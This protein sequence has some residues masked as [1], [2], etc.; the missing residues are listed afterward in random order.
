MNSMDGQKPLVVAQPADRWGGW[1]TDK[2]NSSTRGSGQ[3]LEGSALR[4]KFREFFRTFRLG[5]LYIYRE[6]LLRHYNR[7]EYYIEVDLKH[8][9][10]YDAD[11]LLVLQS[12]PTEVIPLFEAAVKDALKQILSTSGAA[13]VDMVSPP[14]FQIVFESAQSPHSLRNLTAEHVNTL[15]KVNK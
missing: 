6:A 11:C 10:E 4:Q 14:D 15:V 8:V 7:Q 13:S 9:G 5:N 2:N 12:R 1:D 3:Q